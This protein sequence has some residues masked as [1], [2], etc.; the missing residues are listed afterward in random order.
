MV[1]LRYDAFLVVSTNIAV[2]SFFFLGCRRTSST[3]IAN[4]GLSIFFLI[5]YCY[6]IFNYIKIF[7]DREFIFGKNEIVDKP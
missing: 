6:K 2:C 1:N 5:K 3:I 7:P 4:D